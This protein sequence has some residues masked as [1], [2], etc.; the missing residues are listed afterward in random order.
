MN[1]GLF[2][3]DTSRLL[4]ELSEYHKKIEAELPVMQENERKEF[5]PLANCES[6]DE[7]TFYTLMHEHTW[8]FEFFF[9]RYYRYSF[10]VLLF[11]IVENQLNKLCD[12]IKNRRNLSTRVNEL[13]GGIIGRSRT[14]LQNVADISFTNWQF[15][16]DLLKIRN[17]IVHAL[18]NIK[19]SRDEVRLR[20]VAAQQIGLSISNEDFPEV[21]VLLIS[22]EFCT[23]AIEEVR[24]FFKQLFDA[25]GF[26]C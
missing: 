17:C 11:L 12:N 19:L 21:D 3:V 5:E 23:H 15:V 26:K 20:Q 8:A 14:Y 7:H 4:L 25:V 22:E 24:K 10:I 1:N 18:G 16:Y 9:P 13:S 2:Y 6:I